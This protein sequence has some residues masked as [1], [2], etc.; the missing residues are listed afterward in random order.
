VDDFSF[1]ANPSYDLVLLAFYQSHVIWNKA[2]M[3][4]ASGTPDFVAQTNL[5]LPIS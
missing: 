5:L 4:L 1:V 2:I 3:Q